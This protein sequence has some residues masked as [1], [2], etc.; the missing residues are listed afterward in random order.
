M[1]EPTVIDG[2]AEEVGTD[3][4]VR[5]HEITLF[6]TDDPKEI[7]QRA[8]E[9]AEV[10]AK[11]LRDQKLTTAISGREHV[12]VEGWTFCGTMLGV[13]PVCTWSR[14]V[15]NG[16]EARVEARTRDGA[17]VGAAEAQCLRTETKWKTRDDYAVRSMAQT[18]AVSKAM[19][20]PLGFV[21]S[22]AGFDATPAEEMDTASGNPEAAAARTTAPEQ[23]QPPF[24]VAKDLL[25][26]A[27]TGDRYNA[28]IAE[29][30]QGIDPSVDWTDVMAQAVQGVW[31]SKG[32]WRELDQA[33]R[34]V[35]WTRLANT[36]EWIIQTSKGSDLVSPEVIVAGFAWGFEGVLV[37][38][39]SKPSDAALTAEQQEQLRRLEEEADA[40][41]ATS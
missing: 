6:R 26:G 24:D 21:V 7:V 28:R 2:Q 18:R 33:E 31:S 8:T 20:L 10:L 14:P 35:F 30:L 23:K 13:F 11:V 22:L 12:R 37:E 27:I 9:L 5:S 1:T 34:L 32:N 29:A 19:R 15:E 25:P 16:W 36:V 4:E 39:T 3:L 41:E 17:V 40:A 38:L